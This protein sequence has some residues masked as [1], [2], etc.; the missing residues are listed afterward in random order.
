MEGIPVRH[1]DMELRRRADG[2][3]LI[4]ARF[5]RGPG[6]F[7]RFAPP[8]LE[9]RVELDELGAF[10]MEHVDGKRT[11]MDIV[12]AFHERFALNLREAQLCT[13]AFIRT[14][15]KRRLVSIVIP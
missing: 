10:V 15:V 6:L 13:V 14:L 11:V 2:G 4:I 8:M 7:S 9:H 3:L 12:Q 5:P 1:R